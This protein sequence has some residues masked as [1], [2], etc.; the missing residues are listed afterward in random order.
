M[1]STDVRPASAREAAPAPRRSTS[2]VKP[3][4]APRPTTASNGAATAPPA[5]TRVTSPALPVA[6]A[7]AAAATASAN[8]GWAATGPS[9]AE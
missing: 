4:C 3:A 2:V 9:S 7:S 8:A 6:P 5:G 1:D